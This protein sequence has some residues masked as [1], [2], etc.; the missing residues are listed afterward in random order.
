MLSFDPLAHR[1]SW[2]GQP[3]PGVTSILAPLMNLSRIAPDVLETARQKGQAIHR[4]IELYCKDDLDESA[5]PDW[6]QPVLDKWKRFVAEA[7]FRLIESEFRV[8]HPTFR[9]AGTLDLFGKVNGSPA[10]IDIKRSFLAGDVTGLQLAAYHEA[11][12]AQ[13]KVGK[14]AKRFALRLSETGPYRLQ[15]F[16]D[17]N[18]FSIFMA[19]LAV[20][21]WR[22]KHQP[23]E[24]A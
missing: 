24:Q 23:K 21:R 9:Y 15:E 20:K 8:Y 17:R 19:L 5:L 1:Y 10:F 3:V 4:T 11:Y 2:D 7:D 6:L 12:C 13:E 18:D 22:E 14:S 16:T